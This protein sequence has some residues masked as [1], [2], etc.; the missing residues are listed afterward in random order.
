MENLGTGMRE[1]N[2]SAEQAWYQAWFNTPYYHA[3]YNNRDESEAEAFIARLMQK[4][5]LPEGANILDLPCGKGRH[6]LSLFKLGYRVTGA[7]LSPA[8]IDHCLRTLPGEIRFVEHDMRKPVGVRLFDAVLNL[9][10]SFGYFSQ[11]FENERVVRSAASALKPGGYLVLDYLNIHRAL[12]NLVAEETQLRPDLR[13]TIRRSLKEGKLIKSIAVEDKGEIHNYSEEI[14][15][16]N[17]ADFERYFK[18]AGLEIAGVYGD[19]FLHDF[20]PEE[21]PRL[22]F[23]TRL[24]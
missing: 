14:R 4:L 24:S 8:N 1:G 7:D 22:I 11:D 19:Y 3:L 10:T 12:R 23:I 6:S 20:L 21:S 5:P 16:L 2:Q 13:F 18:A 15:L 17:I 9:F